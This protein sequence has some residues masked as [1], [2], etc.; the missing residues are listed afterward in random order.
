MSAHPQKFKKKKKEK[1]CILPLFFFFPTTIQMAK[2]QKKVKQV[3][4]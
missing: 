2:P 4:A 1:A 3:N